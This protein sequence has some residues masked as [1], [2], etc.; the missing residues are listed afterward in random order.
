MWGDPQLS[1]YLG[2]PVRQ[3]QALSVEDNRKL[4]AR[5]LAP[6]LQMHYDGSVEGPIKL[7]SGDGQYLYDT[8]GPARSKNGIRHSPPS[9]IGSKFGRDSFQIR[10]QLGW[11]AVFGLREQRLPRGPLSSAGGRRGVSTLV[12]RYDAV[13]FCIFQRNLSN[14]RGLVLFCIEADF[15]NQILIF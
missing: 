5:H 13:K 8:A 4:R 1:P 6:N 2:L 10:P 15:C 11:S 9:R 12:E 7:A 3:K 14:F